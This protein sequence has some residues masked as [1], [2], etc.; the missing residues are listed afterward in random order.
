MPDFFILAENDDRLLTE[1]GADLL[2]LEE[3]VL[4]V[5]RQ[6]LLMGVGT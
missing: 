3:A 6:L 1:D 4:A 5:L 2:V